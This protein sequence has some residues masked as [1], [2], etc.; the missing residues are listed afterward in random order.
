MCKAR[1][2]GALPGLPHEECNAAHA[3][4]STQDFRNGLDQRFLNLTVSITESYVF[5]FAART[6]AQEFHQLKAE[7]VPDCGDRV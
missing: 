1:D 7:L 4:I 3:P 6:S 2:E 5:L